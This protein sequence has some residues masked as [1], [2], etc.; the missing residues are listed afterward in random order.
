MYRYSMIEIFNRDEA[1]FFKKIFF[2]SRKKGARSFHGWHEV[3]SVD[4]LGGKGNAHR[5]LPRGEWL[6][7]EALNA[8]KPWHPVDTGRHVTRSMRS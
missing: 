2:F 3:E 1:F 7:E 4:H 5:L 6:A 8:T